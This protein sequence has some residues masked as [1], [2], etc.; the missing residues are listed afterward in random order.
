MTTEEFVEPCPLLLSGGTHNRTHR[1]LDTKWLEGP[2]K[3]ID[4]E[5]PRL[6]GEPKDEEEEECKRASG[7]HKDDKVA[8]NQGDSV[9]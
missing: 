4:V 7:A 3:G 9:D 8:P 5:S 1:L 2:I 6:P